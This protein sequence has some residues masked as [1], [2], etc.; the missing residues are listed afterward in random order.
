MTAALTLA[1]LTLAALLTATALV[2]WA[3]GLA[4][5]VTWL[6]VV[7]LLRKFTGGGLLLVAATDAIVLA[8]VVRCLAGRDLAR[9]AA[10]LRPIAWPLLTLAVWAIVRGLPGLH[11]SPREVLVGLHGWFM[12]VPLLW[13]G[14]TLRTRPAAFRWWRT[15]LVILGT[16]AALGTIAQAAW[17][18]D[19]LNPPY[20]ADLQL[21]VVHTYAGDLGVARPNSVFMYTSRL[22]GVLFAVLCGMAAWLA[23]PEAA[24]GRTRV[25]TAGVS[26]LVAVALL[27]SGQRVLV[28]ALAVGT[29]VMLVAWVRVRRQGPA[30]GAA[31]WRPAAAGLGIALLAIGLLR[32]PAL[33]GLAAF[34][35]ET[36][37]TPIA[38]GV[39]EQLR[40]AVLGVRDALAATLAGHGT[41]TAS[42]GRAH[43]LGV[44]WHAEGLM[45]LEGGTGVLAWEWGLPGLAAWAWLVIAVLWALARRARTGTTAGDTLYAVAAAVLAT[46][47][48]AGWFHFT[49]GAYQSYAVQILLWLTVGAALAPPTSATAPRSGTAG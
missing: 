45:P 4:G 29:A 46:T 16:G 32:L 17:G 13:L 35:R 40:Y 34:Y 18:P 21:Q 20:N 11:G 8:A 43:A 30:A 39:P 47:L 10:P 49:A 1:G 24:R 37:L 36:F 41:G 44:T 7:D 19:V 48:L 27:L 33:H 31:R 26:A 42:V 6:L 3:A 22:A 15:A 2:N 23:D 5:L 12:Y 38:G 14:F 25:M 9:N 28:A